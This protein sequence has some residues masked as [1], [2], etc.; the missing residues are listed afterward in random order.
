MSFFAC[1]A[2]EKST[3]TSSQI[4]NRGMCVS[5]ILVE[6][7][8]YLANACIVGIQSSRTGT[9]CSDRDG[10]RENCLYVHKCVCVCVCEC[11]CCVC[12]STCTYVCLLCTVS[13]WTARL[14]YSAPSGPCRTPSK[15]LVW[16]PHQPHSTCSLGLDHPYNSPPHPP[17]HTHTRADK[18][19]CTH[20]ISSYSFHSKTNSLRA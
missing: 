15:N 9:L 7:F 3:R 14:E 11:M 16:L 5:F 4:K 18:H 10:K 1:C 12:F 6:M 17:I 20:I 19:A 2:D 8:V 13:S